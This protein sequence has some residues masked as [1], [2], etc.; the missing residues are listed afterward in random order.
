MSH[1]KE[2]RGGRGTRPKLSSGVRDLAALPTADGGISRLA[3]GR[4]RDAGVDLKPLL[5]QAEITLHQ[6]DDPSTRLP[7]RSQILFLQAAAEALNDDFLGFSLA[8]SFDCRELG[9]LYYAFASSVTLGEAIRRAARYSRITNEAVVFQDFESSRPAIRIS[10]AGVTRHSDV[11]QMEFCL[12]AALRLCRM[13]TR[14]Q[15][16]PESVSM[17]HVGL[18]PLKWR[19][20]VQH[21]AR[22]SNW[23]GLMKS[24][25]EWRLTGL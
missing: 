16:I 3:V 11:Q 21:D 6:I 4:L 7:N 22:F 15:L 14:R 24:S 25:A 12:T 1:L 13:T 20:I 8:Q 17:M 19:G 18:A 2:R 10:Y 9:L 5:K 23:A